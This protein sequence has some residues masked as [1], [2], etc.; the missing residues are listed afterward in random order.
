MTGQSEFLSLAYGLK[1]VEVGG[2]VGLEERGL[3]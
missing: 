1:G 3:N 2:V